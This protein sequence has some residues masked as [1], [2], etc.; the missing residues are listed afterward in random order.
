MKKTI[1]ASLVI[2]L[3]MIG[4]NIVQAEEKPIKKEMIYSIVVDRFNNGNQTND[5][6]VDLD[7]PNSYHGGDIQGIINKL[8]DIKANGF[9]TI[10]LAPTMANAPSQYHG[11]LVEDFFEIEEQFGTIEDLKKL[12]K[13]AHDRNIKVVLEFVTSYVAPSHPL[14][15][16]P[17]KTNW[18]KDATVKDTQWLDDAITLNQEN[19]EVKDMLFK[20]A[21]FWLEETD[22][23]GYKLHA[24]DQSSPAFLREFID[25]LK[26]VKPDIYVL[27]DV[28]KD[29][30]LGN[31]YLNL[32]IPLIENTPM[33]KS[34]VKVFSNIGTPR[35]KTV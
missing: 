14:V 19:P 34:M 11:Y 31:D 7:D 22:I 32:G 18:T 4:T 8:D 5:N 27:G 1:V 28:L 26:T 15:D 20:A 9:T 23:D 16:D 17:A 35:K 21:T 30:Q 29:Q 24:I 13:E 6:Q 10:S 33:Q 25:Q 12:V 2:I 3:S